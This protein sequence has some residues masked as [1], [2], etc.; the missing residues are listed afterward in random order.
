M[1]RQEEGEDP[2]ER[3]TAGAGR[4]SLEAQA[5]MSPWQMRAVEIVAVLR[6]VMAMEGKGRQ[7]KAWLPQMVQIEVH[8]REHAVG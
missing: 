5:K 8:C 6:G 4:G 1:W 2:M 3:T 7:R